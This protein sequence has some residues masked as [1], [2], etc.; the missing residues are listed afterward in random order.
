MSN[1]V[2]VYW[3]NSNIFINAGRVAKKREGKS[4]KNQV[5]VQFSNMMELAGAERDIKKAYAV[6]STPPGLLKVWKRLEDEGV[7]VELL[8]RGKK[9][10]KEQGVDSTLQIHMLRDALDEEPGIAVLLT[11]DGEGYHAGTGFHADLERMHS[12]GWGIEVLSWKNSCKSDM[13]KWAKKNGVF[14]ELDNFY[15]SVT[16]TQG[17]DVK[18]RH[19]KKVDFSKRKTATPR[20]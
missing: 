1:E 7:Q 19:Y 5:R 6:G 15:E 18:H 20:K 8:E 12:K 3:D 16:F 17:L 13:R 11:G 9:T 14:V 2:F 4:A 10:G